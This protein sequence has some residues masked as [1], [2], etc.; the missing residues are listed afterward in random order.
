MGKASI[1][2]PVK[3]TAGPTPPG[4]GLQ[5][6]WQPTTGTV[7]ARPTANDDRCGCMHDAWV[8]NID[9]EEPS[10]LGLTIRGKVRLIIDVERPRPC[11]KLTCECPD[12]E[13]DNL[14][15]MQREGAKRNG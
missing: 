3:Q 7:A 12:Y 11:K 13:P 1:A 15:Y 8:H 6:V 9:G 5:P 10:M 4:S 2:V 14:K